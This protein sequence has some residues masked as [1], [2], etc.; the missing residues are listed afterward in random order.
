[1]QYSPK[2][3]FIPH[4]PRKSYVRVHIDTQ[5]IGNKQTQP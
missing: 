3:H 5:M 2:F 4:L 1:M